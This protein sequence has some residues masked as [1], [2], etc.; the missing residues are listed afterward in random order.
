[1]LNVQA[2]VFE[3]I[4]SLVAIVETVRLVF[5]MHVMGESNTSQMRQSYEAKIN[6][7]AD[8]EP[9]KLHEWKFAIAPHKQF[10]TEFAGVVSS[11]EKIKKGEGLYSLF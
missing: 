3:N 9:A 4:E 11:L 1:M 5:S 2:T 7:A 10:A 6:H 8:D